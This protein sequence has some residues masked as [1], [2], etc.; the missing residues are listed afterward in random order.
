MSGCLR[1]FCFDWMDSKNEGY[2]MMKY[3]GSI[4][5]ERYK[6]VLLPDQIF[7]IVILYGM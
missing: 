5:G 7:K 4:E 3:G 1:K 2:V 6:Q